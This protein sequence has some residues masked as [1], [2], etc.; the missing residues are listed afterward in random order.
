MAERLE[1]YSLRSSKPSPA[2][3]TPSSISKKATSRK[4]R[5]TSSTVTPTKRTRKPK[6]KEEL[7]SME[8]E[9]LLEE[10]PA[11]LP[12]P[13]PTS[14]KR[15]RVKKVE[16]LPSESMSV[17]S[18]TTPTSSSQDYVFLEKGHVYFLYRPKVEVEQV[19][20]L[21]EVQRMYILLKPLVKGEPHATVK[22]QEIQGIT[23]TASHK[24]RLMIVAK[25]KLPDTLKHEKFFGFVWKVGDELKELVEVL[26]QEEYDT[27]TRGEFSNFFSFKSQVFLCRTSC[28][29]SCSVNKLF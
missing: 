28:C 18:S 14:R 6:Q 25:K 8:S 12:T 21:D 9:E 7:K 15:G 5:A 10:K 17:E 27:A 26:E 2:P 19:H 4:P 20:N 1:T 11:L 23:S 3:I 22:E 24:N 16:L 13:Q 29:T